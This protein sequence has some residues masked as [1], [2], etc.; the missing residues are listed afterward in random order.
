MFPSKKEEG[1]DVTWMDQ[2]KTIKAGTE[3][4][5][6]QA[7]TAPTGHEDEK[8]VDI[9]KI[10]LQ[11]DLISSRFGDER[12]YFS[13]IMR[14]DDN[15]FMPIDWW[16]LDDKIDRVFDNHLP[17]NQWTVGTPAPDGEGGW[18]SDVAGAKTM[19]MDQQEKHGCPFY[20]LLEYAQSLGKA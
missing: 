7:Q 11:T 17:E 6:V 12:L 3:L 14:E 1:S 20:W 13:H 18:P 5:T 4:F 10:V 9:A 2:L 15:P 8:M 19:F 16:E